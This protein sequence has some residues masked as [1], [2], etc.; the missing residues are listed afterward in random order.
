MLAYHN[1]S[2]CKASGESVSDVD[3]AALVQTLSRPGVDGPVGPLAPELGSPGGC[4]DD[5]GFMFR[6]GGAGWPGATSWSWPSG[7][8]RQGDWLYG[9]L[10]WL[11]RWFIAD[12]QY[13]RARAQASRVIKRA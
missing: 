10:W 3:A 4:E 11:T 1:G 7:H 5:T 12:S 8:R 9:N 6:C 2:D 13:S